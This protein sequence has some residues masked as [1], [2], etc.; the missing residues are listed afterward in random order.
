MALVSTPSKFLT[1]QIFTLWLIHL[2][3]TP[4]SSCVLPVPAGLFTQSFSFLFHV[5]NTYKVDQTETITDVVLDE[6][7][8][9]KCVSSTLKRVI[10]N[11]NSVH[12]PLKPL[13]L[14]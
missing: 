14:F 13:G 3:Q 11:F 2:G 5:E 8:K 10:K 4:P 9:L 6:F 12:V 7:K 1:F